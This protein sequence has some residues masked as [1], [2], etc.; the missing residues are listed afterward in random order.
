MDSLFRPFLVLTAFA[1]AAAAQTEPRYVEDI[2]KEDVLPQPVAQFQLRQYI[3][4]R[5]ESCLRRRR[6]P[7]GRP[8]RSEFGS[9]S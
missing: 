8:N 3:L 2:L 9:R 7:S 6:Q 1:A 4:Q 5:I